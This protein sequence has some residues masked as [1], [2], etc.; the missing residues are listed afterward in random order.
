MQVAFGR[1]YCRMGICRIR[2]PLGEEQLIN[3]DGTIL[4]VSSKF[5][6]RY[7]LF[8]RAAGQ[9]LARLPEQPVEIARTVNN[10]MQYLHDL[11]ER[12]HLTYFKRTLDQAAAER[13]VADTWLRFGLP[14]TE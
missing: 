9:R 4:T 3:E 7:V 13:F 12:L 1:L 14:D 8:A 2:S 11:R 10:Y 5:E 6:M